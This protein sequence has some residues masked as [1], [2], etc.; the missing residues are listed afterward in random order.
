MNHSIYRIAKKVVE[1]PPHNLV[2]SVAQHIASATL[3]TYPRISAVRVA[4]GKPHV[5]VDGPLDYL[6]VEITRY[7]SVDGPK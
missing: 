5:A 7:R 4:V 6:G 1:G 2:E 3:E